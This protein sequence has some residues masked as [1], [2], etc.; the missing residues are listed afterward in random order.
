MGGGEFHRHTFDVEAAAQPGTARGGLRFGLF[1]QPEQ[2]GHEG[3]VLEIGGLQGPDEV[4]GLC[5]VGGGRV[6]DDPEPVPCHGGF[7]VVQGLLGRAAHQH[8]AGQA[9][10]EGVMDFAGQPGPLGQGAGVVLGA[11]EFGTG[12]AELLGRQP[13]V[14]RLQEQRP[15]GQPGDHGEGCAERRARAPWAAAGRRRSA[16][17]RC[18]TRAPR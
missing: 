1:A 7:A 10:G 14:F 8:D 11:G 9:L 13:L 12:A 17:R 16:Y 15:V 4:A 2:A 3:A 5:Q 6:P 18:G